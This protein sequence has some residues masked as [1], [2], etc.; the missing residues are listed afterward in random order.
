MTETRDRVFE[1]VRALVATSLAVSEENVRPDSRLI[2][3]L[4]A[5]S[6]DFVFLLRGASPL[7]LP[8]TV[9]RSP[10]RRLAPLRWLAPLRS[11][12]CRRRRDLR[13]TF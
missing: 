9:A 1:R 4:G 2:T 8:Y 10:L 12:A 5:D 13:D 7:G 6:L 3:E 11:L